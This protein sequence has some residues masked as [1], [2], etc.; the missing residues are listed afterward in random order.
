MNNMKNCQPI[1]YNIR[2]TMN[3]DWRIVSSVTRT[4]AVRKITAE[5]SNFNRCIDC[6]KESTLFVVEL[7]RFTPTGKRSKYPIV[8]GWCGYCDL[9]ETKLIV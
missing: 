4:V 5:D 3:T 2:V 1:G 6:G 7:T 8:W 9:N